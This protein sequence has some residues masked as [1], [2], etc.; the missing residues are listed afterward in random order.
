[1]KKSIVLLVAAVVFALSI[2]YVCNKA[3]ASPIAPDNDP[4]DNYASVSCP[5]MSTCSIESDGS[6]MSLEC[7]KYNSLEITG[8]PDQMCQCWCA[9]TEVQMN[10]ETLTPLCTCN[11]VVLGEWLYEFDNF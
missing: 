11:D 6:E 1:M 3:N 7:D 8:N 4:Y 9:E 5:V 10:G 2:S